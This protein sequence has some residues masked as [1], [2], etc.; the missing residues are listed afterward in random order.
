MFTTIMQKLKSPTLN[1]N[2]CGDIINAQRR[3]FCSYEATQKP[4]LPHYITQRV[5]LAL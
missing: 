5:L 3:C 2:D 1:L 4:Q